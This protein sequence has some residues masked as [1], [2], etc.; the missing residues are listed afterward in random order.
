MPL[1]SVCVDEPSAELRFS[2][3]VPAALGA[4]SVNIRA[5][6]AGVQLPTVIVVS[7]FAAHLL[8]RM[9][10]VIAFYPHKHSTCPYSKCLSLDLH[11][12]LKCFVAQHR[13]FRGTKLSSVTIVKL[14]SLESTIVFSEDA[15]HLI[16]WNRPGVL[17]RSSIS[18][19][20]MITM[21]PLQNKSVCVFTRAR[22]CVMCVCVCVQ[23]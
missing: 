10:L 7:H 5:R 22:F 23:L 16:A 18:S 14:P 1:Q 4:S 13:A 6:I 9:C 12:T 3:A 8:A 2:Y 21:A 17:T 15:Q 20:S 19:F 11:F